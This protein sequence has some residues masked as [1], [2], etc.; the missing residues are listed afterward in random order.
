MNTQNDN[1]ADPVEQALADRLGKLAA[2]PVDLSR[3]QKTM[4]R[5]IP[6]R[7]KNPVAMLLASRPMRAIAAVL[8]MAITL[9]VLLSVALWSG[10]ALAS[11]DQLLQ[12]HESVISQSVHMTN[13]QSMQAA[14]QA[15]AGTWPKA[16]A[17]PSMPD[18]SDGKVM[19]CC[20]HRIGSAKAAC[21]LLSIDGT[22]VTLAAAN[23]ADIRIPTCPAVE[24]G[25]HGFHVQSH[26]QT[27]MVM[28]ERDGKWYCLMGNL[29]SERLMS[30]WMGLLD[31]EK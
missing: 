10:P 22:P 15:M 16:P 25:G 24:H 17:M 30:F 9:G 18:M 6:R 12:L 13:V 23:A 2:R 27:T 1:F 29:P 21:V 8:V 31:G 19:S 11:T 28:I 5:A 26:G 4:E 20:V 7:R 14:N 3:L